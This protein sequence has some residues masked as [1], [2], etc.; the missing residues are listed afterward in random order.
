[1]AYRNGKEIARTH[2]TTAGKP[3][4]IRLTPDRDSMHANR[5]D[6]LYVTADILDSKGNFVP[7][8]DNKIT[9]EVTGPY[10]LIGVENG[11]ILDMNP[12]KVMYRNAFMGKA[13]LM[14]QSTGEPGLL[15]ISAKSPGLKSSAVSVRSK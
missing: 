7:Y 6:V 3:A 9:F 8:A 12:H 14:L 1:M 5:R 10:R 11:D 2:E 4:R 13:L 15:K